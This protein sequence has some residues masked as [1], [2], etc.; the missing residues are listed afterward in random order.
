MPSLFASIHIGRIPFTEFNFP[1]NDNSPINITFSIFSLSTSPRLA[2]I[3][4]AIGKSKNEPSFLISA[5]A[6]FTNIFLLWSS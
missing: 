4:T 1:S 2:S 5:G 6:K 3:P